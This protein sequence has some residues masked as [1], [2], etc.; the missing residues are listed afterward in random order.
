MLKPLIINKATNEES[1]DEEEEKNI[2]EKMRTNP[3]T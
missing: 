3:G 1:D 2:E